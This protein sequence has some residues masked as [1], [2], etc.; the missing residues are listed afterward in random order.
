MAD[1]DTPAPDTGL[2]DRVGALE[3][4]QQSI[5][6]KLDQLLTGPDTAPEPERHE[7]SIADEIRK[8]LDERDRR[9]PKAEPAPKAEPEPEQAPVPMVRRVEKIMG[10]AE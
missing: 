7:V 6:D 9:K 10:W 4:G 3:T 5:L 8:Q 2:S 1:D